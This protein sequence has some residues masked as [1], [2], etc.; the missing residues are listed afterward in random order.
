MPTYEYRCTKCAHEFEEFQSI[1]AKPLT[2]CPKCKGKI[3]RL[4]GT[5]AGII[6]K[7]SG[8]YET[9]YKRSKAAVSAAPAES[10]KGAA[11]SPATGTPP[12]RAAKEGSS[13]AA[14]SKPDSPKGGTNADKK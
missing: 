3:E 12:A 4:L 14:S 6:F 8:F 13:P 5:G 1:T 9:D 7:G 2:K 11:G 10:A